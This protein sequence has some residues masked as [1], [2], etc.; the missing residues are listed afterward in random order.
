M[1]RVLHNKGLLALNT[2]HIQRITAITRLPG[3]Q[4]STLYAPGGA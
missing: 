3:G 2:V 1:P 4:T